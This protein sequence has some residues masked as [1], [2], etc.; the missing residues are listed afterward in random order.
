MGRLID[1]DTLIESIKTDIAYS[2]YEWATYSD[3]LI[4]R[5]CK[6]PTIDAVSVVHGEWIRHDDDR[7]YCSHCKHIF[8]TRIITRQDKWTTYIDDLGFNFCPNC[9]ADMRKGADHEID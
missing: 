1:A 7:D 5:I 8:K 6:F 9:G 4:E 2:D 3:D